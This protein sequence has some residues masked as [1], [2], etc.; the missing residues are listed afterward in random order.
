MERLGIDHSSAKAHLEA[1]LMTR[2]TNAARWVIGHGNATQEE[3]ETVDLLTSAGPVA[4]LG[5]DHSSAETVGGGEE[6]ETTVK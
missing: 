2:A 5:T 1:T 6:T 3:E 4:R